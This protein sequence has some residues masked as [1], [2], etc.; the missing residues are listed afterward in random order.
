MYLYIM[1]RVD[2]DAKTFV[3]DLKG[4]TAEFNQ[5]VFAELQ[6]AAKD[7]RDGAVRDAPIYSPPVGVK[8]KP[9]GGSLKGSIAVNPDQK[10]QSSY[11]IAAPINYAPYQEFGTGSG[12]VK[13]SDAE[14]EALAAQFIGQGIRQVNMKPQPYLLP[15]VQKAWAKFLETID[16]IKKS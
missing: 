12:F 1:L 2:I 6:E 5:E 7:A 8:N 13:P 3:L 14:I 16:K 10:G 9:I 15:N 11:E 4:L